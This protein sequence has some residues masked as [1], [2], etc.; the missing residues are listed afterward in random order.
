MSGYSGVE[1]KSKISTTQCISI[2]SNTR[3]DQRRIQQTRTCFIHQPTG[4]IP[5]SPDCLA[6]GPFRHC[7]HRL[8]DCIVKRRGHT[9]HNHVSE[10]AGVAAVRH[11][12]HYTP[13]C[14]HVLRPIVAE[15]LLRSS[16]LPVLEGVLGDGGS[17]NDGGWAHGRRAPLQALAQAV[18]DAEQHAAGD[19]VKRREVGR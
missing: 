3:V 12:L 7:W 8:E 6:H 4:A 10:S 9:L 17:C 15:Y 13:Q 2:L 16:L 11:K 5:I 1:L 18:D 19:V 14:N